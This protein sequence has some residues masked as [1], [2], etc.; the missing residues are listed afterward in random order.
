MT[1]DPGLLAI[2]V[3]P[4]CRGALEALGAPERLRCAR[5]RLDYPV[6]DGIPVM[7]PGEAV[8]WEPPPVA[9]GEQGR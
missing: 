5:C 9:G 2:L 4:R 3:C 1:L 8:S 6:R 7:L